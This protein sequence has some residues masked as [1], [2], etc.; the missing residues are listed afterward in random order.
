[1]SQK[2]KTSSWC[3]F[4]KKVLFLTYIILLAYA[5]LII[6]FIIGWQRTPVF[7]AVNQNNEI[8]VSVVI[9]CKNEEHNIPQLLEGLKNQTCSDFELIFVNDHSSDR[10]LSLLEDSKSAFE[11]ISIL[12]AVK[13]GKKNALAQGI[14]IAAGD[15]IV[16]T[17][18]DCTH[19]VEWIRTIKD[20]QE[21]NNCDLIIGPV[22]L[23]TGRG[24][25]NHLQEIEFAFL[26]A[27]GAGSAGAG[28][29]VLCNG[30][31]L[32]FRKNVWLKAQESLNFSELSGDD[33]FLLQYIKRMKGKIM[34]LKSQDAMVVTNPSLDFKSFFS[35]RSRWTSKATKYT[36]IEIIV[37]AVVVAALSVLLL[38]TFFT[39]YIVFLFVF[40]AKFILDVLFFF[41]FKQFFLYKFSFFNYFFASLLYPFYVCFTGLITLFRSKKRW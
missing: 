40:T 25:I 2:V 22:M 34:F 23:K 4:K 7:K 35:Q 37:T 5:V 29:P 6:V 36:D 41:W 24:L 30:A 9:A 20:F 18:A 12:N 21:I 8:A 11:N 27:S 39:Q 14:A 38:V 1:M 32:I 19:N 13:S 16:T 3:N 28:M 26:V 33:M 15:I 17:D 10:T 31:N